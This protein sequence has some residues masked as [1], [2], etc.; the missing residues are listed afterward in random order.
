VKIHENIDSLPRIKKPIVTVG[1]FDGVHV[2]HQKIIARINELAKQ[3]GGESVLL[4]F[5]PHPRLVLFPD[6][7][8]IKLI[9]TTDEKN[10]ILESLGLNHV[11]YLPFEKSF[12]LLSAQE[13][14]RD[15]LVNKIGVH[16]MV[17]GYD[18]HFGRNRLG[19][20][21]LLKEL[22]L[23]YNFKVEEISAHA[24]DAI[25]VSSTKVRSALLE[26][27]IV[28][29][30]EYLG[31]PF[32]LSGI[33][34]KGQQIG[35]TIGYPTAN[36]YIKDTYKILPKL[37]VYSVE[38]IFNNERL[39]GMMNIGSK[40]TIKNV[41]ASKM[42]IEVHIFNFNQNIYDKQITIIPSHYIRE[43]QKF[44]NVEEL[45]IQLAADKLKSLELLI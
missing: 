26:G 14:V 32:V 36:I 27:N 38:V 7:E 11:I 24:I 13:Y 22:S 44:S 6:D 39:K 17:I 42:T 34:E 4:T 16:T 9:T 15:F 40:P 12:S 20:L 31:H 19:N 2:G 10:A 41:E 28:Q 43:E 30:N 33:V 5:N 35:R 1:T 18:H 23:V 8:N 25:N 37:G 21:A 29:A 3:E 45:K